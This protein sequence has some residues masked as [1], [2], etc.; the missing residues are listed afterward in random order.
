M[1]KLKDWFKKSNSSTKTIS[2]SSL[3]KKGA[4]KD[5]YSRDLIAAGVAG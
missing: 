4:K 5:D 2:I 3:L 1:K